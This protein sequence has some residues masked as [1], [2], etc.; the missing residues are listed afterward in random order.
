MEKREEGGNFG[1]E[2]RGREF[3][4]EKE[5]ERKEFWRVGV[6]VRGSW[7]KGNQSVY[8]TK[9]F[10]DYRKRLRLDV[11][12]MWKVANTNKEQSARA[13]PKEPTHV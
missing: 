3:W 10:R 7:S 1:E 9:L 13:R 12:V 4:K 11:G 2:R 5:I 8:K 6:V